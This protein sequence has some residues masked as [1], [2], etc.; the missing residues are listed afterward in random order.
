M[1]KK[2]YVMS[3]LHGCYDDFIKMLNLIEFKNEDE[4]YIIGDIFDRGPN[5]IKIL[6]Y[7]VGHK[8]IHLLKGNHEFMFEEY[9]E[10]NQ[11]R[12]WFYNGG[13]ATYDELHTHPAFTEDSVYEY[14][15][16]LPFIKVIDKYILVHAGVIYSPN[17]NEM[18]IDEFIE[19]QEEESC[20]W[21]RDNIGREI[22]F[23][24]YTVV[25]GHTPT[26][27]IDSKESKIL[28]KEGTIY[29]DCGCVF[30][31]HGGRLACLRL[32]DLEEFYI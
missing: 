26:I 9:Y 27:T 14:I 4:L 20:L 17:Q 11:S 1:D 28:H 29:I 3:D 8:N 12:L 19:Y 21:N 22:K 6:D 24:D 15:K 7:I 23:K 32:N 31:R 5:S 25:C 18:T 16:S 10:T 30:K 13:I 2:T